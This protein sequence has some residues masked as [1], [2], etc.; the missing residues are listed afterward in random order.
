M[1]VALDRELSL[2]LDPAAV[3]DAHVARDEADLG[4]ARCVEE[5]GRGQVTGEVLIPDD[6]GGRPHEPLE[7]RLAVLDDEV[8][9][10]VVEAPTERRDAHVFDGKPD[11][12]VDRIDLPAS[13]GDSL[14]CCDV[15][16]HLTAPF[17]L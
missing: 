1:R 17:E 8:A 2:D 12:R 13:G 9:V 16:A 7:A 4:E 15:D 11:E 6:H 10:V 5:V 14:R 3:S